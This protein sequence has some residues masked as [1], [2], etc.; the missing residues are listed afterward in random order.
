[1]RRIYLP[2]VA[3]RDDTDKVVYGVVLAVA[4]AAGGLAIAGALG[5]DPEQDATIGGP[6]SAREASPESASGH[7]EFLEP[8]DEPA[9][10]SRGG[11]DFVPH[12]PDVPD[13]AN[14]PP[15]ER[16][17]SDRVDPRMEGLGAEMR[18]LSR[19]RDL[20]AEH[21]SEAL[22]V[23]DQH[24]RAHPHGVLCEEREAFAI[25]ALLALEHVAEAERR[26]YDFLREFPDSA[27]RERLRAAMRRPPHEVGASGR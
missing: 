27:F 4:L 2:P 25:E 12:L 22:G 21:P 8:R 11:P 9:G 5:D 15:P 16:S 7:V 17:V 14:E 10:P 26:Y 23:L 1:M 20:I 18:D 6:S 3:E 24:R 13:L 19:A